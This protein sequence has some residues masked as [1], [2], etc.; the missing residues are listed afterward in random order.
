[1]KVDRL[2]SIILILLEKKRVSAQELAEMFEVSP[3]T[4]Y[5]DIDAICMAGIPICATSG[6]GGGFEI[7]P[8]Y[9][10][11]KNVFGTAD[12]T[13]LLMG[14]SSLSGVMREN[15][16]IHTL[17]KI[18]SF[19]PSEQA[20]KIEGKVNQICIDL[21]PWMGTRD[22]QPY[23]EI[24]QTALE[25]NRL[26][27][28]QYLDHHG[29][30]T[31]RT[32]EPYQLVSK[33][34]HWYVQCYCRLRGDFRMFKL[35]RILNL[36]LAEETF[37]PKEFPKPLLTVEDMDSVPRQTITLRIHSSLVERLL[38]Y[39]SFEQFSKEDDSHFIV[40]LPFLEN[41]YYYD[42]LLGFGDRCECLSPPGVRAEIRRRIL[43]LASIYENAP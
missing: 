15:E 6:V 30:Q 10:I 23:V 28:L 19:I 16:L 29:K 8:N 17:T 9:K 31:L 26:L 39:C 38:D 42:M 11:D 43:A 25:E 37:T 20:G 36:Q 33:Y 40:Q 12:L 7:M 4:I 41:D 13:A 5:R 32:V 21:H 27:S 2:V 18:K 24:I 3:R 34:S 1:M 35:T 14:L 22:M